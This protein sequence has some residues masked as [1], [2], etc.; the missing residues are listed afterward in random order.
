M[1]DAPVPDTLADALV[2]WAADGGL[3]MHSNLVVTSGAVRGR[4]LLAT[5]PIPKGTLL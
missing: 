4:A 2:A 1:P 5:E 3:R